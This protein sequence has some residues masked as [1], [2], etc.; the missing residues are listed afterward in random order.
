MITDWTKYSP[1][2]SKA[3]FDCKHTGQNDMKPAFMDKLLELRKRYNKPMQI[4]SG[5]RSPQ[6]PIEAK[7]GHSNGEHTK[8][9]CADVGTPDGHVR[10]E[11]VKLALEL[12]FTRIGVA[13][14]FVH[15]GLGGEGLPN[16]VIWDYS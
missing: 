5:Y 8:G 4:T 9:M 7:K 2:F 10:F 6:H 14:G 15:L 1:Y 16:N 13:K 12:G 3:E 11:L